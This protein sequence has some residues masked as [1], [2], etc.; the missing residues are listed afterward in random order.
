MKFGNKELTIVFVD[1]K[2]A[3]D[4]INREVMFEIL[5]LYG[6]PDKII[7]AIKALYTNT[8]SRV[9]TPDGETEL[10]DIVAGV[11]QGD[12]LAPLLFVIVLDYVLR[13]SLDANKTKGLL[14]KPKRSSRHP[15]EYLTDLD[16][17]DDLAVPPN[18]V[19]DAETL[20]QALEEAA[21][22]VGLYCNA[23][24][25]E[26]QNRIHISKSQSHHYNIYTFT[27][28]TTI[29]KTFT[30]ICPLLLYKITKFVLSCNIFEVENP[31]ISF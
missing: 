14:L 16:F 28:L 11:L 6:I 15:A 18:S 4:S 31:L 24:K 1:F 19:A 7:K 26:F 9:I 20:L 22:H 8:K 21:T 13:I 23:S 17:A 29:H 2:K 3:F 10:F 12:T 27:H 25:T 30:H 5:G